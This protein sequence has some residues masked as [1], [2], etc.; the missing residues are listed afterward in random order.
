MKDLKKISICICLIIITSVYLVQATPEILT[1]RSNSHIDRERSM[2]SCLIRYDCV[3]ETIADFTYSIKENITKWIRD[4]TISATTTS[5]QEDSI[6]SINLIPTISSNNVNSDDFVANNITVIDVQSY[7]S[8]GGNWT[9]RFNT[10]GTAD[11]TITAVNGTEFGEDIEF[12]ELRC[13]D[14]VL[15]TELTDGVVYVENYTCDELGYEISKVLTAGEHTLE[16]R[17]GD[18]IE[19]AYNQADSFETGIVETNGWTTVNTKQT[20]TVPIVVA[21]PREGYE[22]SADLEVST[23]V[24]TNV[25]STSFRVQLYNETN[26]ALAGNVS[27]IVVENGTHILSNGMLLQ[28][29]RVENVNSY[30]AGSGGGTSY[31]SI[32]FWTAYASAPSVIAS[33]NNDSAQDWLATRYNTGTLTTS[34]ID[35]SL[36]LDQTY[37]TAPI[38]SSGVGSG[39]TN[40][41]AWIAMNRTS[42]TNMEA[43]LESAVDEDPATGDWRTLTFSNTYT[44]PLFFGLGEES[45][46]TDP[47]TV[48]RQNLAAGGVDIR[49]TEERTDGEQIHATEDTVWMVF[50]SGLGNSAPTTPTNIT[51]DGSDNCNITVYTTVEINASGSTDANGDNITYFIEASLL[52]TTTSDDQE[53][54]EIQYIGESAAAT[55]GLRVQQGDFLFTGTD[56]YIQLNYVVDTSRAFVIMPNLMWQENVTGATSGDPAMND[57]DAFVTAYIYNSTHIRV[58]RYASDD[59]DLRIGWQVLESFDNEFTVQRGEIA[60]SA[61]T[62][63]ST[64]DTI[65]TAVDPTKTMA[66]HYWRTSYT[67][68]D[69]R[70]SQFYSNVSD[71]NTITFTRQGATS[72]TGYLRWV[73]VEWNTTKIDVFAQGYVTGYG[74]DA[75]PFCDNIGTTITTSQSILVF[76]THAIGDDGLDTSATAGYISSSTQVCFHNYDSTYNRGIKWYVIDFGSGVGNR[77]ES[78]F[79]SWASGDYINQD[80]ISPTVQ[81]NRSL[82]WLSGSCNGDG[83]AKPRHTQWWVIDPMNSTHSNTFRYETRYSG[84][85]REV[86]WEVLELP[87]SE[88]GND[89]NETTKSWTTYNDI[90]SSDWIN[91][92]GL[93]VTVYVS[94]YNSSGS[95]QNGNNVPD[96]QLELYN[97]SDFVEVGNFSVNGVGNF[98]LTV[99]D[100][101]ILTGWQTIANTDLRIRGVDFDY[102]DS[103]NID[104]INYTNIWIT[105]DGKKWTEIGNHTETTTLNWNTTDLPAQTGVDLRTRANDLD[106]TNTYSNYFT[107]GSYLNI[108]HDITPPQVVIDYPQN[109]TYFNATWFNATITDDRASQE[110]LNVSVEIDGI[111]YTMTN[112]SGNWNYQNTTGLPEETYTARIYAN[113]TL[114]NMN[115]TE[116]ITFTI[117]RTKPTITL[118]YP[119]NNT[120]YV[121]ANWTGING[122]ITDSNLDSIW[123]N[124]TIWTEIDNSSPFNFTNTSEI[125]TGWHSIQTTANDSANNTGTTDVYFYFRGDFTPPTVT[126]NTPTNETLPIAT[127]LINA[128]VIDAVSS[129]DAVIAEINGTINVTLT[130]DGVSDHYNATYTF[131]NGANNIRIYANDTL[132]NTN[133]TETITFT[134]AD[135]TPPTWDEALSDQNIEANTSFSYT[136]NASDNIGIDSYF[137]NDTTN[138]VIDRKSTRLNSSHIPLSRMPS[139]A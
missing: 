86:R 35:I 57:D 113:D 3:T 128:T 25:T 23:A 115:N 103:S 107:K 46:G 84:Q 61:F 120:Y 18:D 69:G 95:T 126:I 93:N 49:R 116:T 62:G 2:S 125:T 117:D 75:A 34:G 71:G 109:Q 88:G 6:L 16:F 124:N 24:V 104:E 112:S 138:F 17:F 105:I 56:A 12:L 133:N 122:T 114:N 50:E 80:A 100:S 87:Y 119:V 13:G 90:L 33:P 102:N 58:Q 19:Y 51:C 70:A 78:G 66:W 131:A 134:I 97:G 101:T 82:A 39:E 15:T 132:D 40:S 55:S 31:Q 29:G 64:T 53:S 59:G 36:E 106:G 92:T 123:T 73:A 48:G 38:A 1:I 110:E 85:A 63:T 127:Q 89:D 99:S 54:G 11:L 42:A 94:I 65:P 77:D 41:I 111:N 8:V 9:V 21:S 130:R 5:N 20:Y 137:I 81:L 108:T 72:V 52:N 91:I 129:I 83:T 136:V 44:T 37:G 4:I 76:Q 139:S 118:D 74:T 30:N 32:T 47:T 14:K 28:A 68:R 67:G 98:S 45:G 27:Y 43:A 7:P 26:G 135:T 79:V 121:S 10:T 60:L 22:T 96:L